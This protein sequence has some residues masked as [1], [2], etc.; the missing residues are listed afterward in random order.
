MLV[1]PAG[2]NSGM[3]ERASSFN[4]G[5]WYRFGLY[6]NPELRTE[7]NVL[8][9]KGIEPLGSSFGGRPHNHVRP[10]RPSSAP[11]CHVIQETAWVRAGVAGKF[12]N[13]E[14]LDYEF[15]LPS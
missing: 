11:S 6:V 15:A 1:T 14:L 10:I 13:A 4:S 9:R 12:A 5:V 3:L 8:D 7:R 2:A